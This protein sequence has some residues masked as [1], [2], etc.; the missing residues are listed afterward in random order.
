MITTSV[1]FKETHRSVV[2]TCSY[3]IDNSSLPN[4]DASHDKM[5]H[6]GKMYRRESIL[7]RLIDSFSRRHS[8]LS[9]PSSIN[10]PLALRSN[11]HRPFYLDA[12]FHG[13]LVEGSI[14]K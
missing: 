7:P 9:F 12:G 5:Y 2:L 1:F 4:P 8:S 14:N 3:R 10:V 13:L 11:S 6:T